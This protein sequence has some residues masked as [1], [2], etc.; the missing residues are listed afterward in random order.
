MIKKKISTYLLFISIFTVVTI[1]STIVQKSYSNLL[2]PTEDEDVQSLLNK[3]N[4][5]LDT[6]II[7]E[8]EDRSDLMDSGEINF[9]TEETA[10]ELSI[11]TT[12]TTEE[13]SPASIL[14]QG[15]EE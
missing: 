13:A 15:D 10:S 14:D 11:D 2:G 12:D 5:E 1:F 8:I 3:I 6:S 9:Y 7:Q 4:P